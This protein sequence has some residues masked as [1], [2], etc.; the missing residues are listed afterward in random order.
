MLKAKHEFRPSN[1]YEILRTGGI[2]LDG[3]YNIYLS[4]SNIPTR[5]YCEMK[6]GGWT[7]V[8]NRINRLNSS[9]DRV[10]TDYKEGFGDLTGNYWVGL[11]ALQQLTYQQQ[12]SLRIDVASDDRDEEFIEYPSVLIYP[13]AQ[14]FKMVLSPSNRGTLYDWMSTVHGG[15]PFYTKVNI[16]F[17]FRVFSLL[18]QYFLI[19]NYFFS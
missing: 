6:K 18:N 8:L 13:E 12:M 16:N 2:K 9:F 11:K 5:V 15:M 4:E 10:W 14:R 17:Y 1:C 3:I 19:E 7:R